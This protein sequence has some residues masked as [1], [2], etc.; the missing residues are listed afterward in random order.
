MLPHS[1]RLSTTLFSKVLEQ[2]RVLHTPL[3]S[4]FFTQAS[5]I[6]RFSVSVPKKVS[7]GAVERNKIRRRAYSAIRGFEDKIKTGYHGVL[8]MKKGVE[9]LPFQELAV[10]IEKI[11]VKSG[12][13]K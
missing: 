11:F 12:L 10:E 13:L 8:V 4:L 2:G 7:K 6:S 3:G 9:K 1:K 5:G